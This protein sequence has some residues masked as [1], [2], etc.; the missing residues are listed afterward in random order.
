MRTAEANKAD[1]VSFT[2][3][4]APANFSL[5]TI[6]FSLKFCTFANEIQQ[7]LEL[8]K[9]YESKEISIHRL[10]P[11]VGS[12]DRLTGAVAVLGNRAAVGGAHIVLDAVHVTVAELVVAHVAGVAMPR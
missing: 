4:S 1:Y 2:F 8:Q 11:A 7:N 9:R 5:F 6:H 10:Q 3:L 12:D